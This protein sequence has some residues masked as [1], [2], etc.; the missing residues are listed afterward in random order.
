MKYLTEKFN[1]EDLVVYGSFTNDVQGGDD[2][3]N[4]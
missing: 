2:L 4:R 1:A 3:N